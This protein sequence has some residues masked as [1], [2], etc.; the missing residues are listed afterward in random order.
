[1]DGQYLKEVRLPVSTDIQDKVL[2]SSAEKSWQS[3]VLLYTQHTG[4]LKFCRGIACVRFLARRVRPN[5]DY[6][7]ARLLG[8][9]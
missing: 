3:G 1:M 9:Q 8:R 6:N 7:Q 2:G 5:A 4:N